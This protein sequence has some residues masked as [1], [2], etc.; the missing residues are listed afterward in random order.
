MPRLA[1]SS[2]RLALATALL[3]P[4]VGLLGAEASAQGLSERIKAVGEQKREALKNDSSRAS[5]LGALV[6]TDVTVDFSNTDAKTAFDYL[7]QQ[8]GVPLVVRYE[9]KGG[10]DGIDETTEITFS[11]DGENALTVL[12]RMLEMCENDEDCTWQIR[13]GYIEAGPKSR[14]GVKAAQELRMYP[15]RDLLF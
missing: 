4:A 12:E 14:L 2:G 11:A 8:L 6:Y 5:L 3:A 15:I 1:L 10:A 7:A 9:G 13:D